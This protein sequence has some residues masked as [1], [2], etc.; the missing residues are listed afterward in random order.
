VML[1]LMALDPGPAIYLGRPCYL[2]LASRA[3][4]TPEDWTTRR[5]SPRVV[6]SM[7][8][9]LAT[10]A[11]R[12]AGNRLELFGHSG[13]G[14]LAVLLARRVPNVVRVV[15][16][17]G[18]LDHRAWSEIH[19]YSPLDQS[20]NPIDE[21]PLPQGIVQLHLVGE[22][23]R[24]IPPELVERA[25]RLLGNGKIRIL[26]DVTHICCWE[27]QWPAVLAGH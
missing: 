7:A 20:L 4:C 25:A 6:K 2:G 16:L 24:N 12:M 19:G 15:T 17:A 21:G 3:P 5:Y 13:G 18:N 1:R 26:P 11:G 8:S 27:A 14:T 10:I 22:R 9:A 23:D